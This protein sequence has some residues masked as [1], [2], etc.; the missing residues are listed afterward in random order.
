[1]S[2]EI[3]IILIY[4][5]LYGFFVFL[6]LHSKK[7]AETTASQEE[8]PVPANDLRDALELNHMLTKALVENEQ[9]QAELNR[10]QD[11]VSALLDEFKDTQELNKIIDILKQFMC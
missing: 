6:F 9:L 4:F 7:D 10:Y 2:K 1:M 8:K 11:M 3:I 5:V